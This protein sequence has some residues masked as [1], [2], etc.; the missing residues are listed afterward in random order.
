MICCDAA[1]VPHQPET[2]KMN[3]NTHQAVVTEVFGH[4]A[5]LIIVVPHLAGLMACRINFTPEQWG[6]VVLARDKKWFIIDL[7]A[8]EQSRR[9][10]D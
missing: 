3:P 9:V 2:A 10:L 8:L 5:P 1:G 6:I 4:I 7:P